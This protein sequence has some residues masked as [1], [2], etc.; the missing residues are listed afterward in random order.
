MAMIRSFE[1]LFRI[2]LFYSTISGTAAGSVITAAKPL[3]NVTPS[4]DRGLTKDNA[5]ATPGDLNQ[6]NNSSGGGEHKANRSRPLRSAKTLRTEY[7]DGSLKSQQ[8]V[9]VKHE[10]ATEFHGF[11][12]LWNREGSL[13]ANGHY[14]HGLPSGRWK[15]VYHGVEGSRL[16]NKKQQDF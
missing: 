12:K 14:R 13:I 3:T 7:D 6:K 15:R 5:E 2:V 8:E 1:I 11:Y 10:G 16:L 4:A 9:L